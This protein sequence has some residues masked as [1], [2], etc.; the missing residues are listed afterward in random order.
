[1]RTVKD[2]SSGFTLVELLVVIAIIGVL[3][4]LL[5]PA[6]QAAREAARRSTCTNNLKQIGLAT[7]NFHDAKKGLPISRT[8]CHWATWAVQLWPFNEQMT[9]MERWGKKS[10]HFQPQDVRETVTAT[11][12][13]PSRA[14]DKL[15]SEPGQDN[16]TSGPSGSQGSSLTGAVGD[17][18]GNLGPPLDESGTQ[19]WFDFLHPRSPVCGSCNPTKGTIVG[20]VQWTQPPYMSQ[21][22]T[23]C[24]G[25]DPD[26]TYKGG[27][28]IYMSFKKFKDGTAKTFLYGEKHV[29]DYGKSYLRNPPN[30]PAQNIFDN[31]I[32]NADEAVT[33]GRHAGVNAALALSP[34]DPLNNNFGGP[35]AGVCQFVFG[36]GSVR[37]ISVEI[38]ATTLGYLADRADEK[39]IADRD[40]Y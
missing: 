20:D 3:V 39:M 7:H 34:T 17:Y 25:S 31:S 37:A 28:K 40:I 19:V 21:P 12:L 11:Y 23:L 33:V 29:P 1:M 4:A 18:A 35:H 10:F 15:I 8:T 24:N 14:R 2:S 16:R 38:D 13:C 32:Y 9:L 36:D 30:V 6:V 5:L 27:E 22:Q 26:Y